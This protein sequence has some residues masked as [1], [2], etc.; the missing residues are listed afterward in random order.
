MA[1]KKERYR[2]KE[3]IDV[4]KSQRLLDSF[5]DAV[6][7][8]AAIIDL[9]GEIMVG[10]RW[11]RI[12]T[13]FHRVNQKTL[14]RCIN[15]DTRMAN[16]LQ[17]N[18]RF[19]MYR[20]LNGLTDAASPIII[21]KNHI[22]NAFVGQF[23]L[24]PP[25][26]NFF[27]AR[28]A[29]YGFEEKAYLEALS[30]VPIIDEQRLPIILGFLTTYAEIVATMGLDRQRQLD[31]EAAI[32]ASEERFR[33]TVELLP[34]IVC[35]HD[36]NGR[37][38]YVNTYG[39][40]L[41]GFSQTD[42][43][44]GLYADQIFPAQ[45]E[46][47]KG[48]FLWLLK[49]E[50]QEPG[51][52][53]VK[54]KDGNSIDVLAYCAPIW[55][56]DQIVGVRSSVTPITELT[57]TKEALRESEMKYKELADSLPQVVFE[58]DEEGELKFTN[59]NAFKEFGYSDKDFKE[60]LNALEML[61]SDDRERAMKN[62]T[63]I[64]S[65]RTLGGIEYTALR[66]DGS[67]FPVLI[68]SNLILRQGK[69]AGLRGI[70]IDLSERKQV[71]KERSELEVR[72]QRAEKMEAIG[73]LAGGV[74]HDLNNVLSGIVSYPDLLLIQLPEDSPLRKPIMTIQGAGKKAAAIVQDL[75]TL[76]R[77]GATHSEVVN[78]NDI[79]SG[80]IRSPEYDRLI[81][82]HPGMEVKISMDSDLLNLSGSPVHLSK[83]FMNLVSN[84]AEAMADGGKI[85]I[86]TE[87]RYI[88]RPVTGY[89]EVNE[90]DY[91]V[92]VVEDTGTG[93][94]R[95]D[96][97]RIFEPFY[98]KKKMG[99]SGTGLGMSVVWGTVKDHK[100]YI[101][102]Q[103]RDGKGTTFTL[104]F[105]VTR[106]KF[107]K[108][109]PGLSLEDLTGQRESILVVDDIKDQREI[110][111]NMLSSLNY[112][113]ETVASGEEAFEYLKNQCV[114]L[115]VLDMIMD[116]GMDGLD[117]YR[118]ILKLHPGQKAIITSGFSETERLKKA[119][120]LGAGQYVRKPYTLK[121]IGIAVKKELEK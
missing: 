28:A 33:E 113:V 34:T 80:Y 51:E 35:E 12:C 87:N 1:E 105:P 114:A 93:I 108:T 54:C 53:Q 7:I 78:L 103:S 96:I 109:P 79:V 106:R 118:E 82:H 64:L 55:K 42:L 117:T 66:K 29:Q 111:A 22:A 23:L 119:Q 100:G 3:L 43:E 75:L 92:L 17:K 70:I 46:K 120:R 84:A 37:F 26:L 41:L 83:T 104:Y 27:R 47:F 68:H 88:D 72:L 86:S 62:I 6:G 69:P 20:C 18:Q 30:E 110:A 102:V 8:A 76:A 39:L 121:K 49:K 65:G 52:F 61:V 5:C 101:D 36:T 38:T 77:R 90:G 89:D 31:Y 85:R 15:S 97:G 21:E 107:E 67:T 10:S 115:V 116:S 11:Q 71:E 56:E 45:E 19:S 9:E 40:E 95:D 74:A 16:A 48:Q 91:V 14:T 32:C 58:T 63:A 24:E 4:D 57:R 25:D 94:S 99:R 50:T 73:T 60:G 44:R 81:S 59:L 13:D 2:L 112:S 98:T